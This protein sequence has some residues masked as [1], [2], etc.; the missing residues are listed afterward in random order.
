MGRVGK[1]V[2][3]EFQDRFIDSSDF[4]FCLYPHIANMSY[5]QFFSVN[6]LRVIKNT[7]THE[8]VNFYNGCWGGG[9]FD[10]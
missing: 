9:I 2:S 1:G 3:D 8:L 7:L 10:I 4:S 6:N 5:L